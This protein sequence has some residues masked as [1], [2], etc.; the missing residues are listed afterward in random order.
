MEV[1]FNF[2]RV[3]ILSNEKILA[4][5]YWRMNWTFFDKFAIRPIALWQSGGVSNILRVGDLLRLKKESGNIRRALSQSVL[6]ERHA[7][8]S[9]ILLTPQ[10]HAAL[11]SLWEIISRGDLIP[12]PPSVEVCIQSNLSEQIP[13]NLI[14]ALKGDET[15]DLVMRWA[16]NR[17]HA[18]IEAPLSEFDD[19]CPNGAQKE[20]EFWNWIQTSD[21]NRLGPWI[22]PQP[23]FNSLGIDNTDERADFLICPPWLDR[24]GLIWEI[25]GQFSKNDQHKSNKARAAHW[26]VF[27]HI[28]GQTTRGAITNRLGQLIPTSIPP[29]SEAE[30]YLIDAPWVA[31]QVDLVLSWLL[32]MGRWSSSMPRILINVQDEYIPI[33]VTASEAW[34]KLVKSLGLIWQVD[35]LTPDMKVSTAGGTGID[36]SIDID[37]DAATY[38]GASDLL[39]ADYCIRRIFVP[40]DVIPFEVPK[41]AGNHL[42][43]PV[44]EPQ[45]PEL[46]VIM[47]RLFSKAG[48]RKG[49]VQ[50]I[51]QAVTHKDVLILLPTG[52][53]KSLVFQMAAMMLPGV[54]LVIEPF[55]ALI[56]DQV[57]NFQDMGFGGVLGLHSGCPLRGKELSQALEVS[58]IIYVSAERMHVKEFVDEMVG[59][60]QKNGLDLFVVDEAH[61]VSQ[62]GHS[63]RPAYLDLIERLEAVCGRAGKPRP[64]T[65]ALTAT[66][67]QRVTRDIRALLR[68][69]THPVSL[70]ELAP[71]AFARTNLSDLIIEVN[72]TKNKYIPAIPALVEYVCTQKGRGI[73][74][75]PSKGNYTQKKSNSKGAVFG[76]LGIQQQL[77]QS[78][79][80][81]KHGLFTSQS[82]ATPAQIAQMQN[83]A[84]DFSLGKIGVM[85]ATSA[86]GTGINIQDVSWTVHLGLPSGLEAYY[87]ESGRAGRDGSQAINYLLVD[88]DSSDL[89]DA[90][91][92]N[93]VTE[94]PLESLQ[95]T[96]ASLIQCRGSLARQLDLF[97][98]KGMEAAIVNGLLVPAYKAISPG[99]I[100]LNQAGLPEQFY[101]PSYPGR[102]W[103]VKYV[104]IPLHKAVLK[105]V[106]GQLFYFECHIWWQDLVWK[107][108]HRLAT[109]GV[110]KHGF[111]HSNK[112]AQNS[113]VSFALERCG[114]DEIFDSVKLSNKVYDEIRRFSSLESANAARDYLLENTRGKDFPTRLRYS[115]SLLLR[116]TYR[117]V[118]E[119]RVDSMRSL[120]NYVKE[121]DQEKRRALIEDYFSP[122]DF[123]KK[124]FELCARK[125][126]LDVLREGLSLADG[127]PTW[128]TGIFEVATQEYSG[129]ILPLL[130][131]SISGILASDIT[132]AAH[133]LLSL[134]IKE[135]ISLNIRAWCFNEIRKRSQVLGMQ[136]DLQDRLARLLGDNM[137]LELVDLLGM[138]MTERDGTTNLA[139]KVVSRFLLEALRTR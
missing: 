40:V 17:Q 123:K 98:G 124:I 110:I 97:V 131:R 16:K 32:T 19:E 78:C 82:S 90:V 120:L 24:K 72:S 35:L 52:Y 15:I 42:T 30:K 2:N 108:V 11:R 69:E 53:G 136:D 89:V 27:D 23:F 80:T 9:P 132:E 55:R 43:Y 46:L 126:S 96:M 38:F 14:S 138:N 74:F 28:L 49:Q 45:E 86:F 91:T 44:R 12:V 105:A 41:P 84:A 88:I 94:D 109:L 112:K 103:E 68:I 33:V 57:R 128:R 95:K 1:V 118:Y 3:Y 61:T 135:E 54:T 60:I 116:E 111:S 6:Y 81:K 102:K 127:Q 56:D 114:G 18:P 107:A 62:F 67:S 76:A 34:F 47:Q 100:K 129:S 117:I 119:T 10:R 134:L 66:S 137:K 87:Q 8:N 92:E 85:V 139:H 93:L 50:A 36:I 71:N 59:V 115:A 37:P 99:K 5:R 113:I 106:Q 70:D 75:S 51:Q 63:F 22:H 133:Y 25:H 39:S 29:F 64:S 104:D 125:A 26:D 48:F 4:Q 65:L 130:L 31:S 13:E 73:V 20:R 83:D 58:Q 7:L 79:T 122:S 101:K 121:G 21:I 77:S